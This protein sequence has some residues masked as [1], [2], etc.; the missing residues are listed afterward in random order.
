L[1]PEPGHAVREQGSAIRE[2]RGP[3]SWDQDHMPALCGVDVGQGDWRVS[4]AVIRWLGE[5]IVIASTLFHL[6]TRGSAASEPYA[7]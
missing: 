3:E 6:I 2:R 5:G 1:I 7:E 4:T